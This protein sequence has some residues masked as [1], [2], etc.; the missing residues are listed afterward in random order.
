MSQLS[1]RLHKK[2]W[3]VHNWV[4]LYAGVVIAILSLTGV[5]ALFKFEIDE[6]LNPS[7]YKVPI[8][9]Q[10]VDLNPIIDS[11]N[12]VYGIENFGILGIPQ[13]EGKS[14]TVNYF[15]RKSQ[16]DVKD[17][18]IFLN[19]YN[20]KI[21][22][23]RDYYSSS[24]FF[25]RNLHVRLYEGFFG[26]QIVGLA[27]LALLLSTIT[28]FWIYGRFMKKQLFASIRAKNLRV[29]MADYH[30]LIGVTTLVFNLMIA[31]TG[32]WL[33]LQRFLQPAIAGGRPG[34]YKN[35]K[36]PISKEE[37]AAYTIDY[38][39]A[40]EKARAI[41]PELKIKSLTPSTNGNRT[42]E[43]RGDVVRTAFERNAFRLLLD[44]KNLEE[45]YRYDVRSAS[46]G[47]KAFYIQESMH[48]GDWGGIWLKILY[49]F[50]GVTSGF[51]ALTG[52]VVYLKRTEKKR[53]EHPKFVELKPLLWRWTIGI[54]AAVALLAILNTLYGVVIPTVIIVVSL[55]SS[56]VFLLLRALFLFARRK[57]QKRKMSIN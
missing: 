50:F 18:Q 39:K 41:F 8:E 44:K 6:A 43:V 3:S 52:F 11:L 4:G 13:Q 35:D 42:I 30:K 56:I 25:I 7:L 15:V 24:G 17:W 19:P 37:D 9:N 12:H 38:H 36:P 5:V 22:G 28:G 21:V 23:L 47:D 51:L 1:K 26:R 27:G 55:Y 40:Y 45:I 57:W 32:T 31:I 34:L 16:F 2:I 14:W 49:A 46:L 10:K 53:K 33:G 29:K 48:F 54:T 20:G